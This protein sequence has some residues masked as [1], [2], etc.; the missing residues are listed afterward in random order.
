L[1]NS[2]GLEALDQLAVED[3]LK[4]DEFACEFNSRYVAMVAAVPII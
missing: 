1:T 2:N 4:A 3:P